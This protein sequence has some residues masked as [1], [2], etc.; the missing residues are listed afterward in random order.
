MYNRCC[1]NII[2]AVLLMCLAHSC[3]L[4]EDFLS[5][6][7]AAETN[8]VEKVSSI[9]QHGEEGDRSSQPSCGGGVRWGR[10]VCLL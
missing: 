1:I 3:L 4:T 5:S 2:G 7:D 9:R 8:Q 10:R 6:K